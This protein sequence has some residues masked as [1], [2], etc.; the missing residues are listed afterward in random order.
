MADEDYFR[1]LTLWDNG[2]EPFRMAPG[3]YPIGANMAF[4]ASR[5]PGDPFD[6]RLG[7]TGKAALAFDETELFDR[8][9]PSHLVMY[10]P[11]AV[12]NHWIDASRLSL[13]SV[14]RKMFQFGVG[15]QRYLD[16]GKPHPSYPRRLLRASRYA[17]AAIAARRQTRRVGLDA[18]SVL[19]ELRAY[20]ALGAHAEILLASWPRLSEWV[21]TR[22]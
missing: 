18:S 19:I 8:L 22:V 21:S 10:E 4:R 20:Q 6:P 15:S 3:R 11:S 14:R 16:A 1:P 13:K 9:F 7:H 17:R 12:V 2:T 5:L